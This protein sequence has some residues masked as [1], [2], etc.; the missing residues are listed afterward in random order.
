MRI[1]DGDRKKRLYQVVAMPI[2]HPKSSEAGG[3]KM[4]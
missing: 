4:R 3:Y 2:D 1:P